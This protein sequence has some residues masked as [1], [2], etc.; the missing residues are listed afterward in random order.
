[1]TA[2]DFVRTPDANFD[3][4]PDFPYAPHY[5]D[6]NGLRLHYVDEGPKEA[7]VAL[8]MHGEPDWSYLYRKMIP[9]LLAAG[10]RCIAPDYIGFGR[11]D[12]VVDDNWYV[13]ERH[14]ESITH[15]IKELD[16]NDVTI[17]VQDW[18]GPIGLRQVADMPERFSRLAILNTWLHH[19]EMEYSDG[20]RQWRDNATN[21]F[22]LAMT[23]NDFPC[24]KI[25][26]FARSRQV[27]DAG[28][29]V[30][31]YEAPFADGGKSKA[32]ARR[33]PWCI[34][35]WEP[36]AGNAA[37]QERCFKA[38]PTLG[39]PTHVIFGADDNVFTEDWGR[40]WAGMIPGATFDSIP[41]AGHFVQED[42]GEEV[43]EI[44]LKRSRNA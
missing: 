3:N 41:N 32:G 42:A 36:E 22:W 20:I 37:D 38:L 13:I 18:G 35:H 11:S 21:F 12:K 39:I 15:L 23:D 8:L 44:F 24:G 6:W 4:L 31:A 29:I 27:G 17:F 25:M 14:C 40:K 16:V 9:P 33:F 1:M 10:Y 43:V 28:A 5:L 7:P 19:A 30:A 26:A 34:P 2:P